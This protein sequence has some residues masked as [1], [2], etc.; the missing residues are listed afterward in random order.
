MAACLC[1]TT[2]RYEQTVRYRQTY[3]VD[4]SLP[5]PASAYS[6]AGGTWTEVFEWQTAQF[7]AFKQGR[8]N[9][10][11][12]GVVDNAATL[13]T[14]STTHPPRDS[15]SSIAPPFTNHIFHRDDLAM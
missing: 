13:S 15:L 1:S 6:G 8:L 2:S 5:R 11:Q 12:V 3:G 7:E 14:P 9:Q 4:S 10:A